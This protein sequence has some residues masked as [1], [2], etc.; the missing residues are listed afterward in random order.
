MRISLNQLPDGQA[1]VVA[2]IRAG[3]SLMARMTAFGLKPGR[4]IRVIRRAN[5]QGPLHVRVGMTEIMI[6]RSDAQSVQVAVDPA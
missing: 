3:G 2:E 5:W 1:A 6:R 4:R